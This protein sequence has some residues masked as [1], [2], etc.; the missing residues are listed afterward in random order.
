MLLLGMWIVFKV[1]TASLSKPF[2]APVLHAVSILL[3]ITSF[4]NFDCFLLDL[5]LF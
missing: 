5:R 1:E 2:T 3:F 4:W